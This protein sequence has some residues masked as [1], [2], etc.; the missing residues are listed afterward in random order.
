MT[1][2]VIQADRE[3]AADYVEKYQ[4]A[5]WPDIG[6]EQAALIRSGKQDQHAL[7]QA[8]AA[9]RIATE[10]RVVEWLRDDGDDPSADARALHGIADAI[11]RGEHRNV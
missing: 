1:H 3:R 8:F 7:V 5:V 9:H 4:Y 6:R 10:Q 11:E 2:E